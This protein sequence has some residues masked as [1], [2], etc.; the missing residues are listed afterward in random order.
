MKKTLTI[1][2]MTCGH[3]KGRVEKALSELEGIT[4]AEVDLAAKTATIE[5]NK[6]YTDAFLTE[7][8]DDAGYD[9]VS[10]Q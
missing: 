6:D 5:G 3:C 1:N 10:I 4:K 8:I 2:G 7:L 9:V